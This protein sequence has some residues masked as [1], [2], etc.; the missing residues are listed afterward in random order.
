M[1]TSIICFASSGH[2][3]NMVDDMQNMMTWYGLSS[4]TSVIFSKDR[5]RWLSGPKLPDGLKFT[6]A[7]GLSLN[8]TVVLFVGVSLLPFFVTNNDVT[9]TYDF[10]IR[11]WRYQKSIPIISQS[12]PFY[13]TTCVLDFGHDLTEAR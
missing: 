12:S 1:I 10:Q 4:Q 2:E 5:K 7:C 11:K 8:R 9:L 13:H 6:G 3:C